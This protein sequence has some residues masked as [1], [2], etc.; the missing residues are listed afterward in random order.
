MAS[1]RFS[2]SHTSSISRFVLAG[3]SDS[4]A[5]RDDSVSSPLA[6]RASPVNAK[7]K[8]SCFWIFCCLSSLRLMTY[9][10][11]LLVRAFSPRYRL[12]LSV[13]STF[14]CWSASLALPTSEPN[15]PY[16]DFCSAV[17][18]PFGRFSRRS[19]TKQISRG[20]LS[21]LPCTIAESTLRA[22]D[23]YGLRSTLP[24]RPALAPNI[25]FLFIDS[26]V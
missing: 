14:R 3:L 4:L 7:E 8:S 22:F 18:R 2:H 23:G 9:S 12:R 19:D 10:P 25:R 21:C 24:A 20:K 13:R 17:R 5:A 6:S 1:F 11:L 16:A 15:T 26:H